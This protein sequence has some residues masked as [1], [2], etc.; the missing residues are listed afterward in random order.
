M[1]NAV[2]DTSVEATM[3]SFIVWLARKR[4][5]G[6]ERRHCPERVERFFR[7]QHQQPTHG[8]EHHEAAYYAQLSQAGASE[9]QLQEARTAVGLFGHT[10]TQRTK[11]RTPRPHGSP[12]ARRDPDPRM[13][14]LRRSSGCSAWSARCGVRPVGGQG[15]TTR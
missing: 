12:W 9:T 7:W 8:S 15:L 2:T 5:S 3:V 6:D 11:A 14:A 13:P 1:P 4:P 10:F